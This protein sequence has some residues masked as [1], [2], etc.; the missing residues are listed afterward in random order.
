MKIEAPFTAEQVETMN[1]FQSLDTVHPFT[2]ANDHAGDDVLVAHE[3]GWRC[4]SC[5]YR[6]HWAHG[7]MADK[8]IVEKLIA[9]AVELANLE[10]AIKAK[11]VGGC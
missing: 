3:D 11:N 9:Q 6:Q 7:F 4:P 5:E 1:A 8:G 10:A 2:C